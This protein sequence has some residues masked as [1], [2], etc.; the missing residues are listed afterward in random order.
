MAL[1]NYLFHRKH[2]HYFWEAAHMRLSSSHCFWGPSFKKHCT[3]CHI[4]VKH[5]NVWYTYI[6][7]TSSNMQWEDGEVLYQ[8]AAFGVLQKDPVKPNKPA[9]PAAWWRHGETSNVKILPWS[10]RQRYISEYLFLNKILEIYVQEVSNVIDYP[11]TLVKRLTSQT[12][13]FT[14][15]VFKYLSRDIIIYWIAC[16]S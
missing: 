7:L 8:P 4:L 1:R 9:N 6:T 14:W 5:V 3:L 12:A 11:W 15:G 2:G 16:T 10:S 13:L